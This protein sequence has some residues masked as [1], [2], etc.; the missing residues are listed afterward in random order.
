MRCLSVSAVEWR[1]CHYVSNVL[2]TLHELTPLG[3]C[4]MGVVVGRE[5]ERRGAD[6]FNGEV[7]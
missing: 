2:R 5:P 3:N 4:I 6:R 7:L 1:I